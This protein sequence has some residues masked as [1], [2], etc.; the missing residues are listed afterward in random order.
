MTLKIQ[1]LCQ[2]QNDGC[3]DTKN[4]NL[5]NIKKIN[6]EELKEHLQVL[7]LSKLLMRNNLLLCKMSALEIKN[8]TKIKKKKDEKYIFYYK[9]IIFSLILRINFYV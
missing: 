4:R 2:I 9:N 6:S 7:K 8:Q 3:Q 1:D 5:K